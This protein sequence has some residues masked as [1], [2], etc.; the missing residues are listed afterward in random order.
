MKRNK[1]LTIV[2]SIIIVVVLS[3]GVFFAKNYYDQRY[4]ESDIFYLKV[5]EDQSL[6]IEDLYDMDNNPVEKGKEYE[7]KAYNEKGESRIVSFTYRTEDSSKLLQPNEYVKVSVSE[8]I[9][10]G[11]SVIPE[12]EVPESVLK[13]IK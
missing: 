5:P 3:F 2:F 11:E 1:K 12:D 7:F 13:I 6:V 9:V 4:K 10:L 8:V